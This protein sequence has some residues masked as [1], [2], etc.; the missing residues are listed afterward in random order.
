LRISWL[1]SSAAAVA[2]AQHDPQ[3]CWL[4]TGVTLPVSR[5]LN[6]LAVASHMA[7]RLPAGAAPG[8]AAGATS[9]R[10]SRL[11]VMRSSRFSIAS[12]CL[13]SRSNVAL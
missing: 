5:Q 2:N 10:F 8:V 7:A 11:C 12:V 3:A 9:P 1:L 6:A 13:R 4:T